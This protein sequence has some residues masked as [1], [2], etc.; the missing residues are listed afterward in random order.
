M[1]FKIINDSHGHAA[2]DSVLKEVAR[3]LDNTIRSGDVLA[4][5]GGEEFAILLPQTTIEQATQLA[6]RIRSRISTQEIIL[7]TSRLKTTV[8]IGVST[9]DEDTKDIETLFKHAD[10]ELYKAK[11]SG[12]NRVSSSLELTAA[13]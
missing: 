7:D 2:G 12:K 1:N 11:Q 9:R 5:W 13:Y 8:S 10:E 6:E 3:T 4:R